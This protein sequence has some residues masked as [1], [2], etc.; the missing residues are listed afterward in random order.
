[1]PSLH[2]IGQSEQWG[3]S[4]LADIPTLIDSEEE[5]YWFFEIKMILSKFEY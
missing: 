4:Q 5:N 2:P 1:M 3:G